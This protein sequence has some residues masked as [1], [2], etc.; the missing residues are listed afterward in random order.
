MLCL[1]G[2]L[3]MERYPALGYSACLEA[4]Q[5]DR[6]R[7]QMNAQSPLAGCTAPLGKESSA[8]LLSI[9]QESQELR[10]HPTLSLYLYSQQSPGP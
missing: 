6:L 1:F 10:S 4:V 5:T 2:D 8:L 7:E 3:R 9:E